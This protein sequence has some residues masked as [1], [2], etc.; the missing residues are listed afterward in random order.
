MPKIHMI[1]MQR[2]KL[3]TE[4][5]RMVRKWRTLST[6]VPRFLAARLP[7][8]A[9]NQDAKTL[10]NGMTVGLRDIAAQYPDHFRLDTRT[11]SEWR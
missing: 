7:E 3:G 8:D 10:L 2:K 5:P 9:L 6:Q 4:I 11:V 1:R